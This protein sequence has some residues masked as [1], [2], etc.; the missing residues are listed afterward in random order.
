MTH[1]TKYA[2]SKDALELLYNKP[3]GN[4]SFEVGDELEEV[5]GGGKVLSCWDEPW[6]K[7]IIAT[8]SLDI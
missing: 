7:E 5:T 6:L 2:P 8:F 3:N 4:F 1:P